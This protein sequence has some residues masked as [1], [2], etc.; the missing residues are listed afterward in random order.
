MYGLERFTRLGNH[1]SGYRF[2]GINR[3]VNQGGWY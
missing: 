2:R 3:W 1:S